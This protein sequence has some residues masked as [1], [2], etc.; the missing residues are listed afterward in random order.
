MRLAS[1][2][3]RFLLLIG[4]VYVATTTLAQQ[5]E[6][7]P[8]EWYEADV[9]FGV[10]VVEYRLTNECTVAGIEIVEHPNM[11]VTIE[12][13]I[14][15]MM[16]FLEKSISQDIP[17]EAL[18]AAIEEVF[19]KETVPDRALMESEYD[20]LMAALDRLGPWPETRTMPLG[21]NYYRCTFDKYGH[22][23]KVEQLDENKDGYTD[24][25]GQLDEQ[26]PFRLRWEIEN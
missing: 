3:L 22:L 4:L 8:Q 5:S 14:I 13:I 23:M 19:G 12:Q 26:G 17:K 7:F 21:G 6:R 9:E 16:P 24:F 2:T 15:A 20:T 10:L 11:E 18:S 25:H 1:N